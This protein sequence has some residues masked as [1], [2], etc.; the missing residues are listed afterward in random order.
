[1]HRR[2]FLRAVA[3]TAAL[4]TAAALTVRDGDARSPESGAS[5]AANATAANVDSTATGTPSGTPTPTPTEAVATP[6]TGYEPIGSVAVEGATEAVLT[7]DGETAFV[8]VG[9]GFAVLD[10]RD[11]ANPTVVASERGISPPGTTRRMGGVRDVKY[12]DGRL[13]V[14]GPAGYDPDSFYGIALFDV[15]DPTAPAFLRAYETAYPVHNCD[16][17]GAYAYLTR[18]DREANP[19]L[20][21]DVSREAPREVA[22]WSV[23]DHD[24]VWQSV[25]RP[26]RTLHDVFVRDGFAYLAYWD[27][28]TW[29]L[30]V[31]D[32]TDPEYVAD[33]RERDPETLADLD[34]LAVARESSEPPGNDHYAATDPDGSLLAVGK[35]SWNSNFGK[36]G[37]TPGPG[38]PGGP[39]GIAIYDVA[40]PRSPE[41]LS[42]I[43]PPPTADSNIN[44]VR[45]TAHNFELAA[46]H[47]YSSWYRGGVAVHDL[48]DPAEPERVRYFRRSS[49]TNFW[50]ARL[51]APGGAVVATSFED[52]SA[53][54]APARVYTFPDVPRATP[55]PTPRPTDAT[56]V[57]TG[58]GGRPA[59]E[60]ASGDGGGDGRGNDGGDGIGTDA[61]EASDATAGDGPGFGP[62]A[63]LAGLGIGAWRLLGG[64]GSA[65]ERG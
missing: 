35:E 37:T 19:L 53:L 14:G 64:E 46:G 31:S 21:V 51:A 56:T 30:D 36:E 33:V 3:G 39:S 32:P 44:G 65:E 8:A 16:L 26:L 2:Q 40:D 7:P 55:T 61:T 11:P 62:A 9:D 38:D 28:G 18:S 5:D 13:L 6:T 57:P 4:S 34:G 50:T 15:S 1:M 52:P 49:A 41:H 20:V 22:R 23:L 43:D 48:S 17:A 12:D 59:T 47:L 63:A 25:P 29:V 27:A 58:S 10:L 45:T 42:T 60:T 24:P 54:D